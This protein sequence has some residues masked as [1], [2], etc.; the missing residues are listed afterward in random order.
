MLH[1]KAPA[2]CTAKAFRNQT[3]YEFDNNPRTQLTQYRKNLHICS[4]C[5]KP[6]QNLQLL[7]TLLTPAAPVAIAWRCP[8]CIKRKYQPPRECVICESTLLR[9]TDNVC[10]G[11]LEMES[12]GR[13][14]KLVG[15]PNNRFQPQARA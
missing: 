7:Q 2:G 5:G 3:R 13:P 14:A 10:W 15:D 6:S 8:A 4:Q 1:A 11:C 12:L 9:D